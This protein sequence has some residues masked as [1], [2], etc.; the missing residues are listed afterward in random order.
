[1]SGRS[2]SS[3]NK[4]GAGE[5]NGVQNSSKKQSKSSAGTNDGGELQT[6]PFEDHQFLQ[7]SVPLKIRK[8]LD[9][10]S[11]WSEKS[12][13]DVLQVSGKSTGIC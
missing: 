8:I 1:M 3:S 10:A 9:C 2:L 13:V 6:A 12:R 7:P 4:G 11:N 5:G